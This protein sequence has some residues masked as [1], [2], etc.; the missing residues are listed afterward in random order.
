MK[1]ALILICAKKSSSEIKNKN[2]IRYKGRTLV[3]HSVI[4]AQKLKKNFNV[5]VIC[6]TDSNKI[7][8]IAKKAGAFIPFIRPKNLAKNNSP[9]WFVWKHAINFLRKTE[10]YNPEIF[11]SLSPTAPLRRTKDILKCVN[12]YLKKDKDII[13]SVHK[14][15]VNPYFNMIEKDSRGNFKLCKQKKNHIFNRQKSPQVF[16]MNTVAYVSS[17]NYIIKKKKYVRGRCRSLYNRK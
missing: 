1:K 3:E 11:I 7:A 8:K 12:T 16:S 6:S 14:S 4:Q 2:L 15:K 17:P 10:N 9:E 5:R 13:V